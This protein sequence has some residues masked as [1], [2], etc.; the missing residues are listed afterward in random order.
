MSHTFHSPLI[1]QI[2]FFQKLY[3]KHIE[4]DVSALLISNT[5]SFQQRRSNIKPTHQPETSNRKIVNL[6][7][8]VN[9]KEGSLT[10]V[11]SKIISKVLT[12]SHSICVTFREWLALQLKPFS[13]LKVKIVSLLLIQCWPFKIFQLFLFLKLFCNW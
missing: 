1:N 5:D 11:N 2:S 13:F 8:V 12:D 9:T 6:C 10:V 4:R 3:H 7:I